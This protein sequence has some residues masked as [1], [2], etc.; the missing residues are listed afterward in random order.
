VITLGLDVRVEEERDEVG[1]VSDLVPVKQIATTIRESA[2]R[3]LKVALEREGVVATD[4]QIK[5]IAREVGNNA[6]HVVGVLEVG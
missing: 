1:S 5:R 3:S 4:E 6:A 2:E